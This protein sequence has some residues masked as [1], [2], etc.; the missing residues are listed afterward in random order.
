MSPHDAGYEL[1]AGT[2]TVL[3]SFRTQHIIL[4][5]YTVLQNYYSIEIQKVTLI[6]EKRAASAARKTGFR[7]MRDDEGTWDRPN[8]D[9]GSSRAPL[10]GPT[11]TLMFRP[12][13]GCQRDLK[14]KLGQ[15]SCGK[16]MFS[17][18]KN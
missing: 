7:L 4:T 3:F 8:R 14:N 9:V 11:T 10:Q 17:T 18:N 6:A 1:I 15:K 2:V 5:P 13:G 12:L 16:N